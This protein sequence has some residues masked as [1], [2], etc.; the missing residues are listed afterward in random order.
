MLYYLT[1]CHKCVIILVP[2]IFQSLRLWGRGY[3]SRDRPAWGGS[4]W[5][6]C[7]VAVAL[8]SIIDV[9][10]LAVQV[11]QEFSIRVPNGCLATGPL[12]LFGGCVGCLASVEPARLLGCARWLSLDHSGGL[13]DQLITYNENRCPRCSMFGKSTNIGFWNGLHVGKYAIHGISG[14]FIHGPCTVVPVCRGIVPLQ[15]LRGFSLTLFRRW[16]VVKSGKHY[17]VT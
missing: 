15:V 16:I 14:Y 9:T 4:C 1:T 12:S 8:L 11:G 10:I 2:L 13:I 5:W 7:W 17:P 6:M 3:A